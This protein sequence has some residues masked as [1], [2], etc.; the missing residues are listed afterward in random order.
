MPPPSPR[1][2]KKTL[3]RE[4]FEI[5]RTLSD[6][7]VLA[8]RVRDNLIMDS[9]VAAGM[10]S[11]YRVYVVL[12]AQASDFPGEGPD[13]L[14]DRARQLGSSLSARGYCESD[15][16]SVPILD[17]GDQSRTLDTWYEVG[18]SRGLSELGEL[19]IELRFALGLDKTVPGPGR[20]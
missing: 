5:Y 4:G 2:L 18:M 3:I 15:V 6:R 7:I 10:G 11:E 14:W 12:R 16:R 13:A 9:G 8:D 17:P 20:A 19:V 1:D